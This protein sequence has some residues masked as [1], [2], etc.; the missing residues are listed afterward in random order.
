MTAMT[1]DLKQ[2]VLL[3]RAHR[4]AI[5][6]P[7]TNDSYSRRFDLCQEAADAI[8]RLSAEVGKLTQGS[9]VEASLRREFWCAL[10]RQKRGWRPRRRSIAANAGRPR[11]LT[12]GWKTMR[13]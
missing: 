2:V 12:T 11:N 4:I 13:N 6:V 1:P 8:E 9:G 5:H 3:L 10:K 7:P